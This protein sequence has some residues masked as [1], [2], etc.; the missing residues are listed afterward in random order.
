MEMKWR[1]VTKVLFT[2]LLQ[3]KTI[4]GKFKPFQTGS[5]FTGVLLW[6]RY[7]FRVDGLIRI[8]P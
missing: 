6:H 4:T 8:P 7:T 3:V 1:N 2:V 5:V